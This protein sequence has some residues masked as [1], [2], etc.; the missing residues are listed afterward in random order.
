MIQHST[1]RI[2]GKVQGV[3]FRKSTKEKADE[4]GVVGCVKNEPDGS[5]IIEV[6][7]D[8]EILKQF[9]DWCNQ[10]PQHANV[11]SIEVEGG[12]TKHF[13]SFDII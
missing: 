13:K 6:E 1:I 5:V 8:K 4:L 10:G 9:I 12:E 2:Q 11:E 3:F 7:G